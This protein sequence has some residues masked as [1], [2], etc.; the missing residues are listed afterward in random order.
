MEIIDKLTLIKITAGLFENM[1][2]S[3]LLNNLCYDKL[4]VNN[5]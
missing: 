4:L 1:L 2:F 5:K 3:I